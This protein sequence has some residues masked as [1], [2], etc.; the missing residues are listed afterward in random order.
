MSVKEKT[1]V[2]HML[3]VGDRVIVQFDTDTYIEGNIVDLE[4]TQFRIS[5]YES[6]KPDYGSI[7]INAISEHVIGIVKVDNDN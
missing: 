6:P 7:W 2:V 4:G 1:S 3:A 5:I